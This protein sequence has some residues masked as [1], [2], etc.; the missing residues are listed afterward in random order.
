MSEDGKTEW[1]VDG[2]N[3]NLCGVTF[4]HK[5]AMDMIAMFNTPTWKKML[6]VIRGARDMAASTSLG[7]PQS[8]SD[9]L[10]RA[11]GAYVILE[12]LLGV[13][14]DIQRWIDDYAESLSDDQDSTG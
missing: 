5:E 9:A 12:S 11:N 3:H 14:G 2:E 10:L 7:N 4:T 1:V 8:E 6:G 13:P